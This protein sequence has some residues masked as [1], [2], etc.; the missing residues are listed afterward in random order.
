MLILDPLVL[1]DHARVLDSGQDD[2]RSLLQDKLSLILRPE[3]NCAQM[4][5]EIGHAGRDIEGRRPQ[6]QV[7]HRFGAYSNVI[8]SPYEGS[9]GDPLHQICFYAL[10]LFYKCN[11][12]SHNTT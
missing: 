5:E 12:I 7:I 6:F 1:A 9:F 2:L 10:T 3:G 4:R 8:P 11:A